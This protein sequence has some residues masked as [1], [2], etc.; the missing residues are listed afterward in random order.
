VPRTS[1]RNG[2]IVIAAAIVC[3]LLAGPGVRA[4]DSPV[5]ATIG[6]AGLLSNDFVNAARQGAELAID[7]ANQQATVHGRRQIR[8]QLDAQ[9]DN[10]SP[11]IAGFVANYFVRTGAIGVVGHWATAPAAAAA[12]IYEKAGVAQVMF[13]PTGSEVTD[14]GYQSTFRVVGDTEHTAIYM[15]EAA[16]K[17]LQ[18]KRVG[19]IANDS[20]YGQ[21]LAAVFERAML[22]RS[23]K[24]V[25]HLSLS[26]NTSDFS[27]ALQV[28]VDNQ[29]DVIFFGANIVQVPPFVQAVQRMHIHAK[30]LLT[31]GTV[32]S[33]F[34][35]DGKG[36]NLYALEPSRPQTNCP[37]W[38]YFEQKYQARYGA[39][40][41]TFSRY[42]YDATNVLIQAA[43]DSG[44]ADRR[45]IIADLHKNSY[46]GLN[47]TIAFDPAGNVKHSTF[48]LYQAEP[49]GWTVRKFFSDSNAAA[50]ACN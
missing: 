47:G 25:Q 18:G 21:S 40:P 15:A 30:I 16:V 6:F 50:P 33:Q 34:F 41:S 14:T 27:S 20:P 9:D 23:Q 8:F 32:G 46:P 24:V 29:V 26:A 44:V 38:K 42:A 39:P 13:T 4:A 17:V 31:A 28:M 11:N 37:R 5:T 19:I 10:N 22:T 7:I 35:A 48:T 45:K 49:G 36:D 3:A 43:R 12:A 1:S 2:R